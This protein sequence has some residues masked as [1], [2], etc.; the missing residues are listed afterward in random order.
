MREREG[1]TGNTSGSLKKKKY[2]QN[3]RFSD[4]FI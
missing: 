3:P 4:D 2:E 1:G